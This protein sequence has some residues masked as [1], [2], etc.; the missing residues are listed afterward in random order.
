[1][2]PSN[3]GDN[4]FQYTLPSDEWLIDRK[5]EME[6]F[7]EACKAK[8]GLTDYDI[9]INYLVLCNIFIRIDERTDYYQYFHSKEGVMNMSRDKGAA[10]LAYWIVKYKPFRLKTM[11]QEERFFFHYKCTIND[12]IAAMVIVFYLYEKDSGVKKY[13]TEDKIELMFYDFYNRD[14]SK[15]AMIMYVE[16]YIA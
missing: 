15:E 5:R 14:I 7:I 12:V 10:L 13:F 1:M 6:E 11:E 9:E 16:S 8:A 2:K 4:E 3:L